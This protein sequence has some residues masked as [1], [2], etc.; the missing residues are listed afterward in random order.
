MLKIIDSSEKLWQE[1]IRL[2][3]DPLV[4]A[5]ELY[6]DKNDHFILAYG[7][8]AQRNQFQA[9]LYSAIDNLNASI[10]PINNFDL[11]G[12]ISWPGKV[13]CHFHWLHD[14]TKNA[15]TVSEA[16]AAVV[17]W[18]NLLQRI[19]D[20]GHRILWTVHNVMPHQTVW[21]EQD[22]KIHQMMADAADALHVMATDSAKLTEPY[23]TIPQR[24]IFV[25]PH[26]TY[27]GW[28]KDEISISEARSQLQI[29][30][31]EF[32][33]LSFG[34]IMGYKGYNC[35]MD[36]YDRIRGNTPKKTRLI[37]AG[38]PTEE[39]LVKEITAWGKSKPDVILDL[40]PVPDDKLQLYF[41]SADIA[42]CPYLQTM[43][44]GVAMMAIT[45]N[46]PVIGPNSGGFADL[47]DQGFALS[48]NVNSIDSMTTAMK[49]VAINGVDEI[50]DNISNM[51]K[52]FSPQIISKKFFE[53]IVAVFNN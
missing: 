53:N 41:R 35:L 36:A 14:K 28:Q 47:I 44:S 21:V 9:I 46:L 26:P 34:A 10:F 33:F 40:T 7:P 51:R 49:N 4:V 3:K 23:Y 1:S 31:N 39:P 25:V 27:E 22:Q 2:I 19:K 16:N 15:K 32:V 38:L 18:E 29:S 30:E 52:Q 13:I 48:F 11:F 20:N 43:N 5:S 8:V 42:V 45:F 17:Y 24:K 6:E 37:I 50:K 12:E